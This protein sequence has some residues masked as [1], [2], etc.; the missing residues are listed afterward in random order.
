[1]I[2]YMRELRRLHED[3]VRETAVRV[4]IPECGSR[5]H[6]PPVCFGC[7][8][9]ESGFSRQGEEIFVAADQDVS[10]SMLGEIEERLIFRV[11]AH[12]S[13]ET[14]NDHHF[15]EGQILGE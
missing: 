4:V 15:A 11:A 13:A 10:L 2:H 12:R 5:M 3:G 8:D 6:P 14:L 1:M 9:G 7:L